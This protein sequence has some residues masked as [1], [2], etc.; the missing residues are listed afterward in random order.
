MN[1]SEQA[2]PRATAM[3]SLYRGAGLLVVGIALFFVPRVL[4]SLFLQGEPRPGESVVEGQVIRVVESVNSSSAT[5]N[6]PNRISYFYRVDGKAYCS[7]GRGVAEQSNSQLMETCADQWEQVN[8]ATVDA[9]GAG[10]RVRI[11]YDLQKPWISEPAQAPHRRTPWAL[12]GLFALTIA[13]LVIWTSWRGPLDF[14]S[15]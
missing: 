15:S 7:G 9:Y 13:G 8:R 14:T 1:Q 3:R 12:A 11:F 2:P 5:G 6:K 4:D 10:A